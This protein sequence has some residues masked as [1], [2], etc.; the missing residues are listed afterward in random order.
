MSSLLSFRPR[1]L[2]AA[3]LPAAAA[4]CLGLAAPVASALTYSASSSVYGWI[5]ASVTSP[6]LGD[7]NFTINGPS[8]STYWQ[9][10]VPIGGTAIAS[11]TYLVPS[12]GTSGLDPIYDIITAGGQYSLGY[13]AQ[14]QVLGLNLK[15]SVIT[16]TLN[17]SNQPDSAPNSSVSAQSS[18]YWSQEVL[19]ALQLC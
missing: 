3:T 6:L 14:A 13:S 11:R 8:D 1:G 15:T 2:R 9:S 10:T 18:A 16:S 17:T 4:L 19:P 5:N 7:V 12:G